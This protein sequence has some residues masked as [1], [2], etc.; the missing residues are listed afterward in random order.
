LRKRRDFRSFIKKKSLG[1]L[2]RRQKLRE[3]GT[4]SN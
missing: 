3:P 4:R 1:V 2:S